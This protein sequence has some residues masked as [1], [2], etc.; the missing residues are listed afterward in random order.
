MNRYRLAPFPQYTGLNS[1]YPTGG[2]TLYHAIQLKIEKRFS[3]GLSVLLSFTGDKLIDDF[4]IVSNVGNNTGGIQNT[5][6]L[7]QKLQL[8][9]HLPRTIRGG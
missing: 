5:K 6:P 9:L 4:S 1:S 2:Y 8:E 7:V 3:H